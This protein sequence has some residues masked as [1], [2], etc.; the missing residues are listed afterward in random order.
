M[1]RYKIPCHNFCTPRL[2]KECLKVVLILPS[3]NCEILLRGRVFDAFEAQRESKRVY[4][5]AKNEH[6]NLQL[7]QNLPSKGFFVLHL[8]LLICLVRSEALQNFLLQTGHAR[9][10]S[11]SDECM[12]LPSRDAFDGLCA[13]SISLYSSS[14]SSAPSSAGIDSSDFDLTLPS[15]MSC[16][17]WPSEHLDSHGAMT[18]SLR[19]NDFSALSASDLETKFADCTKASA[20]GSLGNEMSPTYV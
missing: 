9:I 6:M 3:T 11:A 16:S 12:W 2:M 8:L 5:T 1:L 13:S 14:L 10:G 4:Q 15:G 17:T 19:C 20:S 7:H 18:I